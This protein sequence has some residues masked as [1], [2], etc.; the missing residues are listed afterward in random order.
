MIILQYYHDLPYMEPSSVYLDIEGTK[1]DVHIGL[2]NW[3]L[4]TTAKDEKRNV[5]VTSTRLRA[6]NRVT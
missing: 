3:K 1:R 2:T 4:V 5:K 6:A